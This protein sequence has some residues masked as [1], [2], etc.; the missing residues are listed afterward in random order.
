MNKQTISK[1]VL[2]DFGHVS[3]SLPRASRRTAQGMSNARIS[4]TCT[5]SGRALE[6]SDFLF[7]CTVASIA[8]S[9][10]GD[11]P[12]GAAAGVVSFLGAVVLCRYLEV[13]HDRLDCL[14]GGYYCRDRLRNLP[15]DAQAQDLLAHNNP[16]NA[17][18]DSKDPPFLSA[19]QSASA[20]MSLLSSGGTGTRHHRVHQAKGTGTALLW[21]WRAVNPPAPS[22]I[23]RQHPRQTVMSLE[24]T[25]E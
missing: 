10:F 17:Q 7:N 15:G 21:R 24:T 4:S 25:A 20:L 22:R 5:K 18:G 11:K 12:W 1:L 2:R 14:T 6:L 19:M 23:H 3:P 8:V 16:L 13:T 9:V